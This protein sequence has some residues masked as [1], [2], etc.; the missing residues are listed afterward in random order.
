[1]LL[2]EMLLQMNQS[3]VEEES[4]PDIFKMDLDLD[5]KGLEVNLQPVAMNLQPRIK[6]KILASSSSMRKPP[7][8]ITPKSSGMPMLETSTSS[9][10]P[11]AMSPHALT[12]QEKRTTSTTLDH[13]SEMFAPLL[14]QKSQA[15]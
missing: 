6:N 8:V 15:A 14:P 9:A 7:K 4:L 11:T 2:Q 5:L 1:M 10:S 3:Q 12:T 13:T